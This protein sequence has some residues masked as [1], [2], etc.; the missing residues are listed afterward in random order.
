VHN[1]LLIGYPLFLGYYCWSKRKTI[2]K[3]ET[4]MLRNALF[5]MILFIAVKSIG[6]VEVDKS[7]ELTGVDAAD[8]RIQGL[9]A[10]SGG[11]HA[12][13]ATSVQTSALVYAAATGSENVYN[14]ALVPA[15]TAYTSGMMISFIANAENTGACTLNL[16]PGTRPIKK[17]VSNDLAANDILNGQAVTVIYDGANFQMISATGNVPGGPAACPAGFTQVNARYCI[18]PNERTAAIWTTAFN[19]CNNLGYGN[20]LCEQIDYYYACTQ[21]GT[22]NLLNMTNNVEWAWGQDNGNPG[23]KT[24]GASNSCSAMSWQNIG[25]SLAYRCCFYR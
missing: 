14:V 10:P 22:L 9:A 15:V 5:L 12:V 6:Q 7:I 17:Q 16:G 2:A 25:T 13:D 24:T 21:A 1:S 11:D 19:T 18:E 8:R 23:M 4:I 20:R 3:K